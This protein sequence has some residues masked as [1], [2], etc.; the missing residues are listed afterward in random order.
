LLGPAG[1]GKGT[2]ARLLSEAFGACPLSTA[3]IFRAAFAQSL[4]PTMSHARER[5]NRGWLVSDDLVLELIRD[6]RACLRCPVG[7]ILDGFPRTIPQA[8]SLDALLTAHRLTLDAVIRYNLPFAELVARMS[9]RRVCAHCQSVYHVVTRPAQHGDIC[10]VCGGTLVQLPDDTPEAIQTRLQ[11]YLESTQ[12]VAAY[13][14]RQG[15]LRP[16][17]AEGDADAVFARTV[18][19]LAESGVHLPAPAAVNG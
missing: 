16:V 9:G 5:M 10:D 14:D 17:S 15:L 12:Q 7:F 11:V 4:T 2:Q 6:R 18:A 13:Y 1:V 19:V 3:E 8:V